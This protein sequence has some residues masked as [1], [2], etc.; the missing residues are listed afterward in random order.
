M[1]DYDFWVYIIANRNHEV[2]YRSK[3]AALINS[4]NPSWLDLG[5]DILQDR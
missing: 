1:R 3:K 5:T 4:F 2:Q